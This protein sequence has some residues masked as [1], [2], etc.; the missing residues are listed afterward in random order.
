MEKHA[1]YI[2]ERALDN[3]EL[4]DWLLIRE[5]YGIEKLGSIAVSLRYLSPKALS[6]ISVMTHI[7]E[8]KFRC[9]K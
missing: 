6:F 9:C 8:D 2:V 4:K 7:P 3:G 5:Y 1:S